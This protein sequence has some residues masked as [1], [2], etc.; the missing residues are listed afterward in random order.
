MR[1][2]R[3]AGGAGMAENRRS[4]RRWPSQTL[5]LLHADKRMLFERR[6]AFVVE[7][8]EQGSGRIKRQQLLPLLAGQAEPF[9]FNFAVGD[10]A[11]LHTQ[12]MLAKTLA[13]GPF[14]QQL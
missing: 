12:R 5:Q 8:V 9:S 1:D 3:H 14:R 6:M 10:N 7:I 11:R 13:S 4:R 2:T